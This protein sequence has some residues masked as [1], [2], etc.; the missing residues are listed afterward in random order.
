MKEKVLVAIAGVAVVGGGAA[1]LM[2]STSSTSRLEENLSFIPADAALYLDTYIDPTDDQKNAIDDLL[3]RFPEEAGTFDQAK[4]RLIEV[5]DPELEK[6]GLSYKEDIEPWAGDQAALFLLAPAD[7]E[8]PSGAVVIKADDEVAAIQA[9]EDGF[10]GADLPAPSESVEHAGS[11]YRTVDVGEEVP[12][13]Y[14]AEGGYLIIGDEAGVK[15]SLSAPSGDSLDGSDAFERATAGLPE[16]RLLT[17]FIEGERFFEAIGQAPGLTSEDEAGL[18]AMQQ[19]GGLASSAISLTVEDGAVFLDSTSDVSN[20]GIYSDLASNLDGEGS[21]G[22]LPGG[23]WFA[24]GFPDVGD[25]ISLFLDS[26]GEIDS[27]GGDLEQAEADFREETGLDLRD[28]VLSWMGDAGFF[29]QG[30]N[31][32]QIGG[33]LVL[34][35]RDAAK[36]QD[37]LTQLREI[38]ESE[39]PP[40][41]FQ[42]SLTRD[43][44]TDAGSGFA[45]QVPGQPAPIS[46]VAG[47]RVII[48]YGDD[49]FESAVSGED[50]LADADAYG[51]ALDLLGDDFTP[52]FY[53]DIQTIRTFAEAALAFGGQAQNPTYTEEVRPWIEP[54]SYAVAGVRVDGDAIIQRFV[55]GTE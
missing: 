40:S 6:L 17:F 43:I 53:A 7:G 41:E 18:E 45:L 31:I 50:T 49:A 24:F 42:S 15:A 28:D 13:A 29:I 21:L 9:L 48:A 47:D 11:T 1:A 8:N 51:G 32:Q 2:L 20:G 39:A 5:L 26:F 16:D 52:L 19:L 37:A 38:I 44:E 46:F 33:G 25:T 55:I 23:S 14:A 30:T 54:L 36:A 34:E 35:S 27:I 22:Q 10:E 3:A 4:E 12:T